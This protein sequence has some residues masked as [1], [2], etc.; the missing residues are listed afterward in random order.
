MRVGA[1][2]ARMCTTRMP[3]SYGGQKRAL[4]YFERGLWMIVSY[5]VG[6][7]NWTRYPCKSNES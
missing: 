2:L 7:E 1:L 3:G 5:H 6:V 4:D